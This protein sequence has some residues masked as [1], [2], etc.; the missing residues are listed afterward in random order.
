LNHLNEKQ[1]GSKLKKKIDC[2]T[3][4]HFIQIQWARPPLSAG[5]LNWRKNLP[6]QIYDFNNNGTSNRML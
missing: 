3:L 5:Q 6:V 4:G 1:S 2:A